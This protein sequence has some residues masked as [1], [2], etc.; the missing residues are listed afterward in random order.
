MT[1]NNE[2]LFDI[3]IIGGGPAGLFAT[4]YAGLREMK[5]KVIEAD[6]RL[7]GKV[8]VYPQKMI[9]DVGGLTP[10]TGRQ[11]IEQSVE[12]ALTFDPTVVLEQTITKIEK[13]NGNFLL[14]SATGE[15]H[16]TKSVVVAIGA[17]GVISHMKLEVDRAEEFESTNL[18]YKVIEVKD[19]KGKSLLISGGGPT[20]VDWGIDLS[21]IAKD[22]TLIYRGDDVK[23]LEAMK[24]KLVKNGVKILFNT[25]IQ[26]LEGDARIT[27]VTLKNNKTGEISKME[28]DSLLVN[29]GYNKDNIL[30]GPDVEKLG[31]ELVNGFAIKSDAE[32]H[33]GIPGIYAAGDCISY[34]GKVMLIAGA[35]QDATNA[36]NCAKLH[37]EP[38]AEETGIV[39]SHNDL[40]DEKNISY[41]YEETNK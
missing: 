7:G 22:I 39:S 20:S 19:F 32:G 31:L 14:T 23:S 26:E 11:L 36:V 16:H 24:T 27:S 17:G 13:Q 10:I 1:S 4:F 12:Q 2:E 29:H 21:P 15:I 30:L 33:T 40:F 18:F 6:S 25:E 34:G 8:H 9:W 3:T 37:I 41:M 38:G 35:Y 28:I 5:T